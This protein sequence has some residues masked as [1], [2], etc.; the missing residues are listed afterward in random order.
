MITLKT[1]INNNM[2]MEMELRD[3]EI[4]SSKVT[5]IPKDYEKVAPKNPKDK[6]LK[7]IENNI[8]V[9]SGFRKDEETVVIN[10]YS[11]VE[12]NYKS[13]ENLF[14]EE[15]KRSNFLKSNGLGIVDITDKMMS[16]IAG[17]G[18]DKF[19]E[20]FNNTFKLEQKIDYSKPY[21]E[22]VNNKEDFKQLVLLQNIILDKLEE[23]KK[24][25]S[26]SISINFKNIL[27][28]IKDKD[29]KIIIGIGNTICIEDNKSN[30]YEIE[31]Y[32]HGSYLEKFI[33]NESI[34][35]FNQL[36]K[37]QSEHLKDLYK[38]EIE[39]FDYDKMKDFYENV[40]LVDYPELKNVNGLDKN[41]LTQFM[42]SEFPT[43]YNNVHSR[44]LL[45][46]SIDFILKTTSPS[47]NSLFYNLKKVIPE[48]TD[49]ELIK[50]IDPSILTEEITSLI[51][52]E[53]EEDCL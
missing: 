31:T 38:N 27:S 34:V 33:K 5:Y 30:L 6:F 22:R 37:K 26:K 29:I 16:M 32:Y 42:Y 1:L 47:K 9:V 2:K 40:V 12:E 39:V 43:A 46:N 35:T 44:E 11:F 25:K 21:S 53:E 20:D 8:E 18:T 10:L 45:E 19:Y 23:E 51:D 13:L 14:K 28:E 17:F 15:L 41:G 4:D 49:E 24:V 36:E 50:Y 7:F 52:N 3:K 48:I